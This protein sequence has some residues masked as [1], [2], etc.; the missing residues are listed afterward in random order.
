MNREQWLQ[1]VTDLLRPAFTALNH[2]LP[3]N[4]RVTCGWPS[5]AARARKKRRVGEC[6]DSTASGDQHFE[7]FVSP[8]IDDETEAAAVLAHELSHAA[9]GLKIGHR[10]PFVTVVRGLGLEGKPSATTAGAAFKRLIE[11]LIKAVGKYPHAAIAAG[12][13]SDRT[14]TTRLIKCEC[15]ECGY[16][17]RVTRKWLDLVGPPH[18]PGH[19]PMTAT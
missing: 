2:P 7:V 17:A 14:Q 19:G 18:C 11:P 15:N 5:K 4:V 10:G 8:V 9:V 3:A 6:W 16:P 13:S 1:Q 12:N